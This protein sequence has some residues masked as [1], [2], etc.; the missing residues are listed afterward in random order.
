MPDDLSRPEDELDPMPDNPTPTR[1]TSVAAR[2]TYDLERTVGRHEAWFKELGVEDMSKAER[3][4]LHPVLTQYMFSEQVTAASR[5]RLT[6]IIGA[7]SAVTAVLIFVAD[8]IVK[9]VVP[10]PH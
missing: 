6:Y 10:A 4:A 8:L 1:R 5:R 9:Y 7:A 2:R 3:E